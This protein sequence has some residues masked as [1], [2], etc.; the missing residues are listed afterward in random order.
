M[1]EISLYSHSITTYQSHLSIRKTIPY[2]HPNRDVI[3]LDQVDPVE[4]IRTK[5]EF[6]LDQAMTGIYQ[7]YENMARP[8]P[9]SGFRAQ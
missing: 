9:K 6:R 5:E 1:Q 8:D 4:P 7:A 3:L 2:L